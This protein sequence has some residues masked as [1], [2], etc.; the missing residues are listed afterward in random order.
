[1]NLRVIPESE[2]FWTQELLLLLQLNPVPGAVS[3]YWREAGAP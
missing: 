1:M 3:G 2:S